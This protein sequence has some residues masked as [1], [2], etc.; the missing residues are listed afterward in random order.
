[1][2]GMIEGEPFLVFARQE[3]SGT[4][5]LVLRFECREGMGILGIRKVGRQDPSPS[6]TYE[7]DDI[8]PASLRAGRFVHVLNSGQRQSYAL[9]RITPDIAAQLPTDA[10]IELAPETEY[11]FRYLVAPEDGL[12]EPPAAPDPPSPTES[13]DTPE[14]SVPLSDLPAE[15]PEAPQLAMPARQVPVSPALASAVLA[16]LDRDAAVDHLKASMAKV[17]VLQHRVEQLEKELGRAEARE[18]DLMDLLGK[19]RDA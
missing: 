4:G 18:R 6:A 13:I 9:S 10:W 7:E 5:N 17:D 12:R 15:A 2:Y 3:G 19:W 16:G 11:G 14:F 8:D 1:M